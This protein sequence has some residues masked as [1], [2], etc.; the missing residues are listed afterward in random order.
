MIIIIII[1]ESKTNI[2]ARILWYSGD[3]SATRFS[4][5]EMDKEDLEHASEKARILGSPIEEG[6]CL[7]EELQ[8][9]YSAVD[10]SGQIPPSN[11]KQE[12]VLSS[13]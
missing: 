2:E 10:A 11:D 4:N 12:D 7:Y 1:Q 5:I 6:F 9:T 8:Q 3:S 13:V